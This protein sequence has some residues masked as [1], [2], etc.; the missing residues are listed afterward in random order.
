MLGVSLNLWGFPQLVGTHSLFF[1]N[2]PDVLKPSPPGREG[3]IGILHIPRCL[4][5]LLLPPFLGFF[6]PVTCCKGKLELLPCPG[7]EQLIHPISQPPWLP[8][9][10]YPGA[11]NP[12]KSAPIGA[13]GL[14]LSHLSFFSLCCCSQTSIALVGFVL[15]RFFFRL[16][17]QEGG[18][19]FQTILGTGRACCCGPWGF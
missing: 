7:T 3:N 10:T 5:D 14:C 18:I 19:H 2:I 8:F 4:E 6:C 11:G 17:A 1:G 9:Q 16:D 13:P 12:G 15:S